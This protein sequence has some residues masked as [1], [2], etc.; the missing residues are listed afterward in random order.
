MRLPAV[1]LVVAAA[2]A[3]A[4]SALAA[5]DPGRST[6]PRMEFVPPAPGTYELQRIQRAPEAELL[7][8][9]A[10]VKRLSE[11]TTGKITLLTFFYT[12]CVDPWGCPF[13]YSTLS[14]LR[15]SLMA[16]P[17]LAGKVR[18]V[19]VSFDPT[20]DTPAALRQYGAT[21]MDDPR[22]EWQFLTARSVG[23]LLPVLDAFG[24]DVRVEKDSDGRP[25]RTMNHMLK[26]FLIDR[27]GIVRE[28]YSLAYLQQPVMLND[29]KTLA[30]EATRAARA[31]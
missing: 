30:I 19:S 16:E 26:M 31:P 2:C 5:S 28:I 3:T 24:Q 10:R 25:T 18:F 4:C 7:D 13:A 6:A 14:G 8:A 1:R 9:S 11:Y 17:S 23:E 29:I 20:H 21:F 27:E 22:F 15:E 12:Y